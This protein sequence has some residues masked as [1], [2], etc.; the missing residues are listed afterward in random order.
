[1]LRGAG[2]IAIVLPFLDE[3][4]RRSVWAA[5]AP[6]PARAFNIFWGGG[7]RGIHQQAGLVGPLAPLLPLQNKMAFV[8]GI[9]GPTGHHAAAGAAFVGTPPVGF[10]LTASGPSI[11]NEVMRFAYPTGKPPTPIAVQGAGYYFEFLD[12]PI[13]WCKSWDAQ[14]QPS[15]GLVDDPKVLF[16]SF[17]GKAPGDLT[18]SIL[19][20]VVGQYQFY[21]SD[22]SNLTIG[23]R[24]KIA[25]HLEA[26]R[27]LEN[28]IAGGSLL[29]QSGPSKVTACAAPGA[30]NPNLYVS[31]HHNGAASGPAVAAADLLTS[32]KAM[33][34]LLAMGVGCDLLRFGYMIMGCGGDGFTLTGPYT[35]DGQVVDMGAAGNTHAVN[36]ILGD[37]AVPGIALTYQGWHT[38]FFL[39]CCSYMIQQLDKYIDPNGQ[40]ILDNSL[41]MLGTDLEGA[42]TGTSVFYGMSR[43]NGKFKPGMYDVQGVLLDYLF[44]C[45]AAMGLGGMPTMTS[46]IV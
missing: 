38:H 15:A 7:A 14:G 43:A 3:M 22:A 12:N 1:L 20:T 41:V 30:P 24:A 26:I 33:A 46:F 11:D 18:T 13:R 29:G 36:H 27:Q 17:F 40:S 31:V 8:R 35:V 5:P 42:V 21:M 44:S 23:S 2:G 6:P 9:R 37:V 19:D 4:R 10:N 34:D 39:E 45:K 32:Y 28:R 16:A 25:D